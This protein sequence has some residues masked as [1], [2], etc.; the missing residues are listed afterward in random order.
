MP[1]SRERTMEILDNE[2]PGLDPAIIVG[3]VFGEES[4]SADLPPKTGKMF[5]SV[6]GSPA[7]GYPADLPAIETVLAV[8]TDNPVPAPGRLH[9]DTL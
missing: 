3:R 4:D 8:G 5:G 2:H 1:F 9:R 6:L 7:A